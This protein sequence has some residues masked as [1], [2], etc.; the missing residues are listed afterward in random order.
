M[1]SQDRSARL[2]LSMPPWYYSSQLLKTKPFK[3]S[4][5][6]QDMLLLEDIVF[7]HWPPI[8]VLTQTNRIK[9]LDYLCLYIPHDVS[10]LKPRQCVFFMI[11]A[12]SAN[13]KPNVQINWSYLNGNDLTSTTSLTYM[14][15]NLTISSE[16]GGADKLAHCQAHSSKLVLSG[17][18]IACHPKRGGG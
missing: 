3:K 12:N 14:E 17:K 13:L 7:S 15:R 16:L 1:G 11:F 2:S 6:I 5:I 9:L 10:S 4:M 8:V 18:T